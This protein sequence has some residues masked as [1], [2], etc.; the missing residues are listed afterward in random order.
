[1]QLLRTIAS[2]LRGTSDQ[3]AFRQYR[4]R[5]LRWARQAHNLTAGEYR[6]SY[7]GR[8]LDASGRDLFLDYLLSASKDAPS[9][10]TEHAGLL[11]D[12]KQLF[13][14]FGLPVLTMRE[15]RDKENER[16]QRMDSPLRL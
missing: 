9:Y 8:Y 11:A 13:D 16:L 3:E 10:V 6:D 7:D 15:L 1:M 5:L 4:Q 12:R 14:R 2:L